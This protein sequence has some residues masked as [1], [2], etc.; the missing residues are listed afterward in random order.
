[1]TVSTITRKGQTTIPKEIRE[2]LDLHPQQQV[3]FEPKDGY[4]IMRPLDTSLDRFA[5]ALAGKKPVG[6]KAAER[7][8]AAGM[9]GEKR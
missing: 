2:H 5:G 3:T 1:M 8:A 4:V 6:T 7:K 9:L